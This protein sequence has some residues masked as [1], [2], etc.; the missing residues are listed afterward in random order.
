MSIRRKIVDK[1]KQFVAD[2]SEEG[3]GSSSSGGVGRFKSGSGEIV[4][5]GVSILVDETRSMENNRREREQEGHR[6]Y[7][8][9]NARERSDNEPAPGETLGQGPKEHP[10]LANSQRFDGIDPN[11]N[12]D[13]PLNSEARREFDN[14]RREQEK[15]KQLRLGNMPG[16]K[17][18]PTPN[19]P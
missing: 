12:P 16:K 10:L 19:N 4:P 14:E 8:K 7:G 2:D 6:K 5:E 17:F 18:N 13:P 15:E 1:I 9:V 3:E 11:L